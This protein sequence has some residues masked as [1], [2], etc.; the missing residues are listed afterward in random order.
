MTESGNYTTI[1]MPTNQLI[2]IDVLRHDAG[3]SEGHKKIDRFLF[4]KNLPPWLGSLVG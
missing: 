1:L 3:D 4:S 2:T